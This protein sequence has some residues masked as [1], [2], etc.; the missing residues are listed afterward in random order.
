MEE[1]AA[2]IYHDS[3]RGNVLL[4]GELETGSGE[5]AFEE[6]DDLI[7]LYAWPITANGAV[8][9]NEYFIEPGQS[10]KVDLF[11]PEDAEGVAR[12]AILFYGGYISW[13]VS[14]IFN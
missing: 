9:C 8:L 4:K 1:G 13:Q 6:V 10:F 14:K 3:P 12:P 5:A 11:R 7:G 2:F